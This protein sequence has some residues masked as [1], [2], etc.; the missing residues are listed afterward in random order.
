M[1]TFSAFRTVFI[2]L[3]GIPFFLRAGDPLKNPAL[4]PVTIDPP[5][6]HEVLKLIRGGK[7]SLAIAADPEPDSVMPARRSV[8]KAAELLRQV[9]RACAGLDVPV[10]SPENEKELSR[11]E[12]WIVLGRNALSLKLTGMDPV[13]DLPKEGFRVMTVPRGIVIAGH[14]G[15]AVPG[16]YRKYDW[17][18]YRINGTLYGAYDFAERFLGVRWYYPGDG[19]IRP[20]V[21]NLEIAPFSYRDAPY[22]VNRF[23][24]VIAG[25]RSIP[26]CGTG[27]K[28][29]WEGVYRM[30]LGSRYWAGH[31]GI[32]PKKHPDLKDL[33]YYTNPAGFREDYFDVSNLKLTDVMIDD[34]KEYYKEYD[35]GTLK[36]PLCQLNDEYIVFG[37][38]DVLIRGMDTPAI[39]TEKLIP[40]SRRGSL[41]GE[42][43]DVYAR[44]EIEYAK[45]IAKNFPGKRLSLIPYHNYVM[46]PLQ[47]KFRHFPDN[48]DLRVCIY[49]FPREVPNRETVKK[50]RSLLAD[51]RKVLGGRPVCSLWLYNFGNCFQI[52]PQ[53][54]YVA[55]IPKVL[56][57]DLGRT[58]LFFDYCGKHDW[59]LFYTWYLVWRGMWNPE[60]DR[61]A[62][63]EEM[64]TLLYGNATPFIRDFHRLVLERHSRWYAQG[65]GLK[66]SYPEPV[67]QKLEALLSKA[68][69][70][71]PADSKEA[72]RLALFAKPWRPAIRNMRGAIRFE[73]PCVKIRFLENSGE[74]KIDGVI[75][76]PAWASASAL[77][78]EN[79]FG[80]GKKPRN[81]IIA[82][83]LWN[84]EGL[85]GAFRMEGPCLGNPGK[86]M[87]QNDTLEIFL[88][89]GLK[90]IEFFHLALDPCG[91]RTFGQKTEKPVATPYQHRWND[92]GV[93]HAVKQDPDGW[94]AE[95]FI[96]WSVLKGQKP[97]PYDTWLGNA[98]MTRRTPGA[99][100]TS[101]CSMT[102]GNNHNID[103]FG[104][105]KFLGKGDL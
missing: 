26:E 25:T 9:F 64:W 42:L 77:P 31:G 71:V 48:V 60:F 11:Y 78:I 23:S 36:K 32:F 57:D 49:P 41:D 96:P 14:D 85:Y 22:F 17:N 67:L 5:P 73:R 7:A 13:R 91:R 30:S 43:S 90:Q 94:S 34:L 62:A 63:L 51:W 105:F 68:E 10:I 4:N 15:S 69:Q 3:L 86:G 81:G 27:P 20:A 54:Y 97:A 58:E 95:F 61:D 59:S 46:P 93:R 89:P 65:K 76:E 47:E 87:W 80:S 74:L 24:H 38:Q 2:L 75:S 52:V 98:V 56:G 79:A 33:F 66:S 53:G 102:L 72:R 18:R 45:K 1:K 70:A 19:I 92:A 104:Y 39:R 28:A 99:E 44:F 83:Y 84:E 40:E 50:W 21:K 55:D 29:D 103:Q 101:A 35:A 8:R 100:E 82:K 37:Q 12:H 16:T 6:S 88:S